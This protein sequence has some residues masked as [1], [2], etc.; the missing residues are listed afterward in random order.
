[1]VQSPLCCLVGHKQDSRGINLCWLR[2]QRNGPGDVSYGHRG[3]PEAASGGPGAAIRG[4]EAAR[5]SRHSNPGVVPR[6]PAAVTR[7]PGAGYRRRGQKAVSSGT[8][9]A[10][11]CP[12]AAVSSG[13]LAASCVHH[14]GLLNEIGIVRNGARG[15][16]D[17]ATNA[18]FPTS[19]RL[20]SPKWSR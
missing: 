14:S 5:E 16:L 20:R 7:G 15:L 13:L 3:G 12:E 18:S 17:G 1:M 8:K 2:S 9:A 4:L 6:G 10:V 11:R 19:I